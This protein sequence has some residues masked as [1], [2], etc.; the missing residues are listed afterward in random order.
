MQLCKIWKLFYCMSENLG[1]GLSLNHCLKTMALNSM[2][3]L[4]FI[5][6]LWNENNKSW[7]LLSTYLML[8]TILS[9]LEELI[10]WV[11]TTPQEEILLFFF[12]RWRIMVR[13]LETT[14]ITQSVSV[15]WDLNLES[16]ALE[17]MAINLWVLL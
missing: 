5:S 9:A 15:D 7:H 10:H 2:S 11:L 3:S 4:N 16:L 6:L 13:K 8:G 12:C 1:Q 14:K 17:S